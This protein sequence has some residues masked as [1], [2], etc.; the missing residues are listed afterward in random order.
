[1]SADWDVCG[2]MRVFHD[3]KA[4]KVHSP[5]YGSGSDWSRACPLDGGEAE[6]FVWGECE[7]REE[8][9]TTSVNFAL[10]EGDIERLLSTCIRSSAAGEG[11]VDAG[12]KVAM[13]GRLIGPEPLWEDNPAPIGR[14]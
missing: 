1:M 5:F 10:D 3:S 12:D 6:A 13:G 7:G 4:K 2:S 8:G 14:G 9:C 11:A